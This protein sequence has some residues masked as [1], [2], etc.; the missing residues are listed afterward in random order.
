MICK[1]EVPVNQLQKLNECLSEFESKMKAL[2]FSECQ[3]DNEG[4]ISGKLNRLIEE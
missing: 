4:L 3:I 2:G 1:V